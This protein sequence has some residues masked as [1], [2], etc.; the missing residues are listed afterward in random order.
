[1]S[2]WRKPPRN[3]KAMVAAQQQ[4]ES[5]DA[6]TLLC[7]SELGL[8]VVKE[9]RFNPRRKWRFDYAIPQ[10]RVALEVEGGVFSQGRHVRPQG[11]LGDIEKYNT[12]TLMGWKLLRTT[13]DALLSAKTL[14]M[15]K[16][17]I[18]VQFLT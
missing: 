5:S 9:H 6:F 15:L 10:Y 8:T 7:Q 16:C 2:S 1:M 18:N 11:F 14:Q 4:K 13:P 3:I 17:A 12:A